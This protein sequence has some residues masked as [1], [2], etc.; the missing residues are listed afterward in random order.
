MTPIY[1]AAKWQTPAHR[2]AVDVI[3]I[4]TTETPC[5]TGMAIRVAQG[6]AR[7]DRQASAHYV[8]DPADVVCCV[9]E[10]EVAWHCPKCNRRG[11][12]IEHCGYTVAQPGQTPTDW[13]G[14]GHASG[15]LDLSA[16]LVAEIAARWQIP[17]V[18]LTLDQLRVGA[19]GIISHWDATQV[20][21]PGGHVDGSSWP[22]DAYM[23]RLNQ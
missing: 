18:H 19:R 8:I 13:L 6:F 3:V 15:V 17:L 2:A 5:L 20:F 9:R 23:Q 14:D 1:V 4:H 11:I 21:T 10:T 22:W 12:G 16:Q 7:G